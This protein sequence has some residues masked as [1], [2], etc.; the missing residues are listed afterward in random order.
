MDKITTTYTKLLIAASTIILVFSACGPVNRFTKAKKI[1]REYSLNYCGGE[2]I[3]APKTDLNKEPWIVYSDREKNTT[4][5]NPGGKVKAKDV[6]YLDP[7]LVIGTK[8]DHLR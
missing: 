2:G 1:P 4:Y 5:N 7:F 3:K 6:D 8:G